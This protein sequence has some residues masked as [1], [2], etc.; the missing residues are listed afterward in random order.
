MKWA[1]LIGCCIAC[2]SQ[3]P[4]VAPQDQ[5]Q[6]QPAAKPPCGESYESDPDGKYFA[7]FD[8]GGYGECQRGFPFER[9]GDHYPEAVNAQPKPR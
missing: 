8:D 6:Q 3:H 5:Q 4:T 9:M 7:A 2:A 1:V